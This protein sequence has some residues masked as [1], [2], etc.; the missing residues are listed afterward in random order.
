[1]TTET[2]KKISESLK[3]RAKSEE[4]KKKMSESAKN[5]KNR[6]IDPKIWDLVIEVL[7]GCERG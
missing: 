6:K 5:R 2:K 3:G 4:T 1:M 7:R